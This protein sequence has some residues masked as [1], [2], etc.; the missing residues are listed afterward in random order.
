VLRARGFVVGRIPPTGD[1]EQTGP[2]RTSGA[3]FTIAKSYRDHVEAQ[4]SH[5]R[6]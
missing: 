2:D 3:E 5:A 1:D 6:I 4:N